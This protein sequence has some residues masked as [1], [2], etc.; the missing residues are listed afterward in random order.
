[1]GIINTNLAEYV[2]CEEIING[3]P[4][5]TYTVR[6]NTDCSPARFIVIDSF[7]TFEEADEFCHSLR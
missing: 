4:S 2:V 6:A 5:K 7:D 3:Q 1:M